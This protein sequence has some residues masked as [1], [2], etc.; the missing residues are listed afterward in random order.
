MGSFY[1]MQNVSNK[2]KALIQKGPKMYVLRYVDVCLVN[3]NNSVLKFSA[4][5]GNLEQPVSF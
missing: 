5:N 3:I 1:N 2:L 4:Q